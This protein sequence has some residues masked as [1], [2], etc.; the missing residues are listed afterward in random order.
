[1]LGVV[2]EVHLQAPSIVPCFNLLTWARHLVYF[3]VDRDDAAPFARHP[4]LKPKH[5]HVAEPGPKL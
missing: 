2:A 1:M 5:L 3:G 4:R